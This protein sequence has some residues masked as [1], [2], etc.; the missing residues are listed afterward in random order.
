[1]NNEKIYKVASESE[2][3]SYIS[4]KSIQYKDSGSDYNCKNC[5]NCEKTNPSEN[6]A[7]NLWKLYVKKQGGAFFCHRC[8]WKGSF[9]EF[10]K[11]HGDVSTN[12]T[13]LGGAHQKKNSVVQKI[14]KKP[15]EQVVS[16]YFDK[17][18]R[19]DEVLSFLQLRGIKKETAGAF[20]VGQSQQMFR[21]DD[22]NLITE[23][24]VTFP[25]MRFKP[26]GFELETLHVVHRSVV[27][28]TH[29]RIEPAGAEL[30]LFGWHN[31]TEN[32]D[33]IIVTEGHIDCMTIYQETGFPVVS[34]PN[35][36]RSF[37][38]ACVDA[39]KKFK[40]VI[41]ALDTD[42]PGVEGARQLANKI[43]IEKC[44]YVDWR[45]GDVDGPKDANDA[46]MSGKSMIDIISNR[47]P[48]Q[49]SGVF[50]AEEM[51]MFYLES[52]KNEEMVKGY[53]IKDACISDINKLLCGLRMRELTI[54]SANSGRGKTTICSQISI[55]LLKQNIPILWISTEI[56][57]KDLY[58]IMWTQYCGHPVN[59]DSMKI[60]H[61]PC[62]FT[63]FN[64]GVD[65]DAMIDA[66]DYSVMQHNVK[67]VII[68]NLQFMMGVVKGYE[69][70]DAQDEIIK[71]IRAV[72]DKYNIH[73]I[74]VAHTKKTDKKNEPLTMYSL[75]GSARVA[76][77][78]DNILVIQDNEKV[79][80]LEVLKNRKFGISDSEENRQSKMRFEYS[81]RSKKIASINLSDKEIENVREDGNRYWTSRN[82]HNSGA[83]GTGTS[84]FSNPRKVGIDRAT[85]DR[86]EDPNDL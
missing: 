30:F 5:P 36:A 67:F 16:K 74:L 58:G 68:D 56:Q 55:D 71:K 43:G 9:H 80:S 1:V 34:L 57:P 46:L 41:L 39:L 21:A 63:M 25:V 72:K 2:I 27:D 28:K 35:G 62:W 31:I 79:W 81:S 22:G 85:G 42:L 82:K 26:E 66:I 7:T 8:G 86:T 47:K 84:K 10:K 49:H 61:L 23:P 29:M 51:E 3:S 50:T 52:L 17:E 19:K 13:H 48:I 18:T 54:F 33:T 64:D 40:R 24:C 75:F 4:N 6:K 76:Q 53:Q 45:G 83:G 59:K 32:D 78:A 20:F 70:F 77:E 44:F 11:F 14:F 38:P 37:P 73:I 60:T 65:I 69:K 12:I 15:E